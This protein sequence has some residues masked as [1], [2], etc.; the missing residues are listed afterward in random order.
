VEPGLRVASFREKPD[1]QTARSFLK[2]GNYFWNS[3][4]FAFKVS[5]YLNE[6][7][8]HSPE[9]GKTFDGIGE[10]GESRSEGGIPLEMVGDTV[11]HIYKSS[12]KDSIDYAVMEKSGSSAMVEAGFNW[13]DIGSWDEMAKLFEEGRGAAGEGEN[14]QVYPVEAEGNF[15]YSDLPVALCGV[16]DL[17]VVVKNGAVLVTKKGSGQLVKKAVEQMKEEGRTDIL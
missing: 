17:M 10:A 7:S 6:L 15:V 11:D 14:E 13:N 1:E 16:D 8:V 2:E 4:M 3:G 9:I 12:P 5:T